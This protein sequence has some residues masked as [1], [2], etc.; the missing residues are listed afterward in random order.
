MDEN[1]NIHLY[2]KFSLIH[3]LWHYRHYQ[4]F[5]SFLPFLQLSFNIFVYPTSTKHLFRYNPSVLFSTLL[6]HFCYTIY[7]ISGPSQSYPLYLDLYLSKRVNYSVLD[8]PYIL[9]YWNMDSYYKLSFERVQSV[10][11]ELLHNFLFP[12]HITGLI[13]LTY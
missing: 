5:A 6:L 9:L 4:T 1:I 2:L 12:Y 3:S 11:P 8:V 13:V 7:Y 10:S